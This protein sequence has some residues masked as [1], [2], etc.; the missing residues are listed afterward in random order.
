[1][2]E[3]KNLISSYRD[4]LVESS[5]GKKEEIRSENTDV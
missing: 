4:S 5:V 1:M 3:M 2:L